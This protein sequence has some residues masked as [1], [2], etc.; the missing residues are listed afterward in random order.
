MWLIYN[1]GN[2]VWVLVRNTLILKFFFPRRIYTFEGHI[3]KIEYILKDSEDTEHK[4]NSV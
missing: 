4:M 1:L 3:W 2:T